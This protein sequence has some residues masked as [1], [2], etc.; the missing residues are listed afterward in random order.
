MITEDREMESKGRTAAVRQ[1]NSRAV[2]S[3]GDE[4]RE[5]GNADEVEMSNGRGEMSSITK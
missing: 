2:Q 5:E 1:W 4:S 3:R